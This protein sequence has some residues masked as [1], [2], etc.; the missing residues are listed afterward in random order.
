MTE[1]QRRQ[2][3][4]V[5]DRDK[6]EK[7]QAEIKSFDSKVVMEL[8]EI[9]SRYNPGDDAN[10]AIWT[11]AQLTQIVNSVATPFRVVADY[12]RKREAIKKVSGG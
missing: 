10:K 6:Y 8:Y 2:Q 7:A 1:L 9:S 12:E 4:L 5:R 11:L 3:E